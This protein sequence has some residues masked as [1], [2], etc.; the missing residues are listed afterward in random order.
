[1]SLPIKF[2]IYLL[3]RCKLHEKKKK[4]KGKEK[5]RPEIEEREREIKN[6]TKRQACIY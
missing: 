5:K 3:L 2:L 6:Y 1:M 4:R